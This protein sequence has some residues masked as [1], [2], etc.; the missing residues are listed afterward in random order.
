L[1]RRKLCS[2]GVWETA[3]VGFG[4]GVQAGGV[5]EVGGAVGDVACQVHVAGG[6]AE[7]VFA[8]EPTD[9]RVVPAG[10]FKR[11]VRFST[12]P[13]RLDMLTRLPA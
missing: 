4:L 7:G 13:T 10:T 2:S 11:K 6:E 1:K 12:H 8:D 5:G 3:G 9:K